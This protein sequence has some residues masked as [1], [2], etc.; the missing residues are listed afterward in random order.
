MI[1]V[2]W[3]GVAKSDYLSLLRDT[4]DRSVNTALE[5][6]EK[7]ERL[8]HNLRQFRHFCPPSKKFPKFR[9]CVV[10][11]YISLVYEVGEDSITIISIF[12]TRSPN[13][14]I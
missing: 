9:R 2:E 8:L 4:Y 5:L 13:P 3:T 14:F 11:Q 1:A 7:L 6:D 10:T 12:D